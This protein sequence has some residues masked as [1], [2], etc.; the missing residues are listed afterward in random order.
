MLAR[1]LA[2]EPRLLLLDEPTKHLDVAAHLELLA[3][4]REHADRGMTIVSALHDLSLAA[5]QA[6]AVVVIADGRVVA[7]GPA[8]ATLTPALI[9]DIYGVTATW[10][11]NPVTGRPMLALG[12]PVA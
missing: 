4:L 11:G 9:R 10:T 3:L 1:A 6:D 8:R 12:H 7:N 2:Q 5:D